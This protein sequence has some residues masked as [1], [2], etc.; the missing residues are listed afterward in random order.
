MR[1]DIWKFALLLIVAGIVGLAIGAPFIVMLLMAIGIIGMQMSGLR[2]LR[3]WVEN[4]GG[5]PMP[6]TSGQLYQLH[7]D[8]TCLLY[9]SDA[10]DED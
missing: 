8:L 10:A 6:E 3:K 4:P 1:Q 7:R 2:L 9:T 5:N